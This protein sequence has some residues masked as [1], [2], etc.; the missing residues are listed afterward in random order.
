MVKY[1]LKFKL[2]YNFIFFFI[3]ISNVKDKEILNPIKDYKDKSFNEKIKEGAFTKYL[4]NSKE[5]ELDFQKKSKGNF[6]IYFTPIDCEIIVI[7]N[8]TVESKDIYENI[9]INYNNASNV[10][11][12]NDIKKFTIK[13]LTKMRTNE[14]CPLIISIIKIDKT[15]TPNLTIKENEPAFLYFNKSLKNI[16]LNYN[17]ESNSTIKSPII[18]SF[19]IKEKIKFE[20]KISDD[21][22]SDNIYR[23]I[24][25]KENIIIKPKSSKANYIISIS[26]FSNE[27]ILNST[28]IVKIIKDNSTPFYLQ[29]NQLNLGFIP[30]ELD[31][32]YYY[33]EVF[34]GEEGEIVLFNKRQNGILKGRIIEKNNNITPNVEKFPKYNES[35]EL[36]NGYLEFNIYNHYLSYNSSHTGNCEKGCFLLI[37]YYS[38]ISKTLGISGTEFSLLS[39]F[40]DEEI[41]KS[42]IIN[43]P[44]NEYIFGYFD[45][46]TIN[47]HY[48]S[49]FIPYDIDNIYIEINGWNV[50]GYS[51]KGIIQINTFKMTG[52]T[53]ILFEELQNK[54]IIK[55]KQED[56]GLG[57]FKGEYISFAFQEDII[58]IYSYYYFRILQKK[59]EKDYIIYPLDSNKENFCETNNQKCYFLLKTEYNNLSNK[60]LFFGFGK[61][62]VSYKVSYTNDI[63]DLSFKHFEE[64][65]EVNSSNGLLNLDL[66]RNEN[67]ALI[68]IKSNSKENENL[69]IV[70]SFNNEQ[71]LTSINI[72]F[73]GCIHLEEHKIYSFSISSITSFYINTNNNLT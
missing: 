21:S 17:F 64:L 12:N 72:Y 65:R 7:T 69:T 56:I 5:L 53:K 32:Y 46:N 51:K 55:L 59:T 50:A 68:E 44:L 34:K 61:N 52:K 1:P 40:W 58:D 41:F 35:E 2:H 26:S 11:F 36:S 42:Q 48:Y 14:N 27:E 38:N 49:V 60:I 29:K 63:T 66:K 70:S 30:I 6:L 10:S 25:Y 33:M 57:S 73:K 62:D 20:I 16:N 37:T 18:V 39:R 47:I 54:M 22:G 43:I 24:S 28:M 67:Y 13:L 15:N 45:E 23:N 31:F 4:N 8:K 19:F 9:F 3:L 71:N